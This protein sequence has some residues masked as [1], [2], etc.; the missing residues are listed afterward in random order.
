MSKK[1]SYSVMVGND[2]RRPR[3]RNGSGEKKATVM[4]GKVIKLQPNPTNQEEEHCVLLDML[5]LVYI[6]DNQWMVVQDPSHSWVNSN[7]GE[8]LYLVK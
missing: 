6:Q 7:K 3:H 5:R 1:E 2:D 8:Q 4:I